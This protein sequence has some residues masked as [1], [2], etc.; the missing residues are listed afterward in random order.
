MID[1][2]TASR[3]GITSQQIDDTLYDAFGQRFVSTMYTQLNQYHVVLE[4]DPKFWQNPDGLRYIF[5]RS[6]AP[7]DRCR[8]ARSPT[9]RPTPRRCR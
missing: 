3:L 6:Q 1:R 9:T 7:A 5:V 2:D 8:S 4:V